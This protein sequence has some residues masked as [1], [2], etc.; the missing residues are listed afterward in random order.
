V[1]EATAEIIGRIS[2]SKIPLHDLAIGAVA[3]EQ[4]Y[5]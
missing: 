3:L 2:G 5:A 1:A 4:G